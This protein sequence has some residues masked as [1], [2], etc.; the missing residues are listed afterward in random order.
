MPSAG[1]ATEFADGGAAYAALDERM[2]ETVNGL[3]AYHSAQYSLARRTGQFPKDRVL[4][5]ASYP[6]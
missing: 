2:K 3:S 1:A 4:L 5:E 6:M